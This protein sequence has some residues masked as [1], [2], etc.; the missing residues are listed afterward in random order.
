MAFLK[1]LED[2]AVGAVDEG[3]VEGGEVD[4]GGGFFFV[5]EAFAYDTEGDS[6]GFG[7][8]GPGVARYIHGKWHADPCHLCNFLEIEVDA[9]TLVFIYIARFRFAL[10]DNRQ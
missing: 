4:A 3:G 9:F 2:L 7:Y 10:L 8:G 6:F 1:K 5:S